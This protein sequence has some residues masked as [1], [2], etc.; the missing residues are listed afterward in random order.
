M[1]NGNVLRSITEILRSGER[2]EQSKVDTA[3]AMMQLAASQEQS[4]RK[5]MLQEQ[6]F[7]QTKRMQEIALTQANL[8]TS[9]KLLETEKPKIASSFMQSTGIGGYYQEIEEG[10]MAEDAITDMAK[11]LRKQMGKGYDEQANQIAGA[12]FNYYNAKDAD[13]MVNMASNLYDASMA[14]NEGTATNKQMKM[15]EAF[16]RLGATAELSGIAQ[17]AKKAKI[18]EA[19]ISKEYSEFLQGDYEIQSPIG[20]YADIPETVMDIQPAPPPPLSPTN[21]SVAE[22]RDALDKARL[23]YE[24][25]EKKTNA[26]VATEDEM[27]EYLALP[28]V[29][30]QLRLDLYDSTGEFQEDMDDKIDDTEEKVDAYRQAGLSGMPEFVKLKRLL[31]EQKIQ[32]NQAVLGMRQEREQERIDEELERTSE[33]T[34]VPV[35]DIKRYQ[36]I[37][38]GEEF[39]ISFEDEF[40]VGDVTISSQAGGRRGQ[41]GL[42]GRMR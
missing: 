32:R 34:G 30:K 17:L 14:I 16:T 2:R 38:R 7:A 22:I 5:S 23:K 6:Q 37:R 4:A 13:S 18:S 10:E 40:K 1:A 33:L 24:S 20:I 3:L 31:T 19:N 11:A 9:L 42:T 29:I 25:L 21:V 41:G 8:Q 28:G 12:V 26:G 35:E 39:D 15:F 27:E 36:R